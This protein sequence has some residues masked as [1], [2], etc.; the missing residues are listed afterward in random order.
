LYL[1]P[2][3]VV[4][5]G[6]VLGLAAVLDAD[7]AVTAVC[8]LLKDEDG[9]G[10]PQVYKLPDSSAL[11]AACESAS[12]TLVLASV[13][14]SLELAPVE[15]ASRS[16]LMVRKD[17]IRGMNYFDERYGHAWA[18][19]ELAWQIQNA[20]KKEVLATRLAA[21]WHTPE[22][23]ETGTTTVADRY[24][25]AAGY[26]GK[27]YGFMAG[28]GFR[29]TAILKALFGFRF[30]LLSGLLSGQKIDGTQSSL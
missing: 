21:V 16:A 19:L 6:T 22:P 7:S 24:E 2:S 1:D 13:D 28:L 10:C 29:I 4:E 8:P 23:L 14:L 27:H 18:D 3:A 20:A 17:F 26:L 15:Y 25:G 30:G 5:P 12:G 11:A 9:T